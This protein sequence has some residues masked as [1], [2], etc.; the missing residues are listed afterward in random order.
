MITSDSVGNMLVRNKT[1]KTIMH[2]TRLLEKRR[3]GNTSIQNI[4]G[5]NQDVVSMMRRKKS[6]LYKEG[7]SA[8]GASRD[9]S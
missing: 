7:K 9:G 4:K 5:A 8:S 3:S 6:L 2:Q 1:P